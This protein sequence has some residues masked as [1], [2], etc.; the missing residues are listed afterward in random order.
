DYDW[1]GRT[2]RT[3]EAFSAFNPSSSADKTTEYTYD[4][5]GNI[6]TLRA[7]EPNGAGQTT[8]YVYGVS[9]ATGSDITSNDILAAVRHPDPNTGQAS[10]A[11]Q[12]TVTVNALGEIKTA[13][14]RNGTL[15]TYGYDIL[16]RQINDAITTLGTGVDGSV[17]RIQTAYDTGG[18][19]YLFTS[20]DA[21]T[22]GNIVNQVQRTYNGLDQLTAEYQSHAG[23]V[24]T[25]TIPAVQYAYNQMAGGA[26]NSR[27]L[28]MTYP[29]GRVLNYNYASGLDSNIS[30]L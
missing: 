13:T 8:Q 26:N 1:L 29:N 30:R 28:S 24:N 16:G 10:A 9:A 12:D 3:V 20:Y 25:S 27:L 21:A 11:Q 7:D 2:L 23:A 18:R 14:D 17:R 4:G 19:R 5:D 15:H 22:G 6:L